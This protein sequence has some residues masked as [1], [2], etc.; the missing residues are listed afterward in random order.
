M[1]L[2]SYMYTKSPLSEIALTEGIPL[3]LWEL[4]MA[5]REEY[6]FLAAEFSRLQVQ[7]KA[8]FTTSYGIILEKGLPKYD[9]ILA[10]LPTG[11]LSRCIY[12]VGQFLVFGFYNPA[13]TVGL[14]SVGDGLFIPNKPYLLRLSTPLPLCEALLGLLFVE[15]I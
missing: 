9:V 13:S 4:M 5:C 1:E 2:H 6:R 3:R 12:G 8:R 15:I 14:L 11:K 7:E 10:K